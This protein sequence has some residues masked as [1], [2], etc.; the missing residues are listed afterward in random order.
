M[1]NS[2]SSPSKT[3]PHLHN[4]CFLRL[5]KHKSY[6]DQVPH[7]GHVGKLACFCYMMEL[8]ATES[9]SGQKQKCDPENGSNKFTKDRSLWSAPRGKVTF[10]SVSPSNGRL[11]KI[12]L[13]RD[14]DIHTFPQAP[15]AI[16]CT[17]VTSDKEEFTSNAFL[18][19]SPALQ[20]RVLK[21]CGVFFFILEPFLFLIQQRVKGE[22]H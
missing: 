19:L 15:P 3:L 2:L 10:C 8:M 20:T 5:P 9:C 1:D 13:R 6:I 11:K 7:E 16:Q 12:S 17:S 18:F 21:I 22:A 4:D 14:C